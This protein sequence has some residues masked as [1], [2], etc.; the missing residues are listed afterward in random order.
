MLGRE[1]VPHSFLWPN[2]VPP[3]GEDAFHQSLQSPDTEGVPTSQ[4]SRV[5]LLST[6]AYRHYVDTHHGSHG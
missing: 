3:D 1:L 5:L 4:L 2:H 6:L